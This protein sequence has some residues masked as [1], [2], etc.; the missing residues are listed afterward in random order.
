MSVLGTK[1]EGAAEATPSPMR[2]GSITAARTLGP[3]RNR[4]PHY[5][6]LVTSTPADEYFP[7]MVAP[8]IVVMAVTHSATVCS[9]AIPYHRINGCAAARVV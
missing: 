1:K 3:P 8:S 6:T 5:P 4:S 7:A 9:D 2:V